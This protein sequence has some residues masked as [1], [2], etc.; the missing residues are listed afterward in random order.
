MVKAVKRSVGWMERGKS[1]ALSGRGKVKF[2]GAGEEGQKENVLNGALVPLD[3]SVFDI[4]SCHART[5]KK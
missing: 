2:S 4:R 1:K 3:R 5:Q